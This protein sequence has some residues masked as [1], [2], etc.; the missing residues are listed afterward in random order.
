MDDTDRLLEAARTILEEIDFQMEA[1]AN[2][3]RSMGKGLAPGLVKRLRA[4]VAAMEE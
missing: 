3:D 1:Y 2:G 4:A